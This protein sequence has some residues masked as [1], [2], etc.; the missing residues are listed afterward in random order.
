[1]LCEHAG[2]QSRRG[3]HHY[4]LSVLMW[5][6]RADDFHQV[7]VQF[8]WWLIWI[9]RALIWSLDLENIG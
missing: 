5:I 6:I 4:I 7:P 9:I 2:F 3:A 1:M 8:I